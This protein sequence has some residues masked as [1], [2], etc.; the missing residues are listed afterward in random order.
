M[1]S[2]LQLVKDALDSIGL[3]SLRLLHAS[4]AWNLDRNGILDDTGEIA[5]ILIDEDILLFEETHLIK[6]LDYSFSTRGARRVDQAKKQ[7]FLDSEQAGVFD[8]MLEKCRLVN[9]SP[10]ASNTGITLSSTGSSSDNPTS[11]KVVNSKDIR[12]AL[13]QQH[14]KETKYYTLVVPADDIDESP[15]ILG[16]LE[17]LNGGKIEDPNDSWRLL[18]SLEDI[19]LRTW[20]MILCYYLGL[21]LDP[22]DTHPSIYA[23]SEYLVDTLILLLSCLVVLINPSDISPIKSEEVEFDRLSKTPITFE[24]DGDV[25]IKTEYPDVFEL[26][27][28]NFSRIREAGAT[29]PV[30]LL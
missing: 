26:P 3:G 17:R 6:L 10:L 5:R 27:V 28:S 8:K 30:I 9:P 18:E 14:E 13:M 23:T 20:T 19:F 2:L 7:M 15:K 16:M 25:V 24:Q 12:Y 11:L 4:V 21:D 22:G 1:T 29:E